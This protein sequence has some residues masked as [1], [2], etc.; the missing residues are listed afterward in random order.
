MQNYLHFVGHFQLLGL[1]TNQVFSLLVFREE[2]QKH[3]KFQNNFTPTVCQ[4]V[5]KGCL[6]D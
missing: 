4:S 6:S 2:G 1:Q 3:E 5:T